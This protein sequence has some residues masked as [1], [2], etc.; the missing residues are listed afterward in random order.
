[1]CVILLLLKEEMNF[2][3]SFFPV[4]ACAVQQLR[5]Q[6]IQKQRQ[7]YNVQADTLY[8]PWNVNITI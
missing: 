4:N 3:F 2:T 7:I 1:M 5:L 6:K 8:K